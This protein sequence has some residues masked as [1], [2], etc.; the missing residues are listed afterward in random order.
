MV[1]EKEEGAFAAD[2][3]SEARSFSRGIY[4]ARTTEILSREDLSLSLSRLKIL[5][6]HATSI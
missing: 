3:D 1:V 6:V 2:F 4:A 5:S